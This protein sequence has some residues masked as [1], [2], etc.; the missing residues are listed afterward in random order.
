MED[1]SNFIISI[2]VK[3]NQDFNGKNATVKNC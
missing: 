2:N 1:T 3:N